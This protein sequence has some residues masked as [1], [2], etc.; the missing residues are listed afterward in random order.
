M[1]RH[2]NLFL[3]RTGTCMRLT[4]LPPDEQWHD[5]LQAL[6]FADR[7]FADWVKGGVLRDN[8]LKP[9]GDIYKERRQKWNAARNEGQTVPPDTELARG[10]A[11]ESPAARSL[12]YL[13]YLEREIHRFT[14]EGLIPLAQSHALL[15][16]VR[17]RQAA[18]ERRLAPEE[19]PEVLLAESTEPVESMEVPL[20]RPVR[21]A[22]QSQRN[23]LEILL[24]PRNIQ[25]LLAFGGVLMV[26][27]LVI[28][29]W[30]NELL[31]PPVFAVALGIGNTA[32]LGL[33]WWVL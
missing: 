29:L 31:T 10:H 21:P 1:V 4:D 20:A 5:D 6:D 13:I 17:E 19:L 25:I 16:D 32:L 14:S 30:V 7:R 15:A 27:G 26:V 3:A 33:G 8:R 28:L 23:L 9:F 11:T 24:D 2:P 18:L 22:R 12:R